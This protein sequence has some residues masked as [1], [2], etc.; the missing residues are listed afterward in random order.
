[1]PVLNQI[2]AEISEVKLQLEHGAG[3]KPMILS[4]KDNFDGQMKK[5]WIKRLM[6]IKEGNINLKE[7]DRSQDNK[8]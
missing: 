6:E 7:F 2:Y 5:S 1:M 8:K 3:E 4:H